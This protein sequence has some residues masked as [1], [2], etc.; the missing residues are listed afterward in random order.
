MI[1]FSHK[2]ISRINLQYTVFDIPDEQEFNPD[3]A[4]YTI[5]LRKINENDDTSANDPDVQE[6]TEQFPSGMF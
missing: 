3:T 4:T 6:K 5:K 2:F 1:I